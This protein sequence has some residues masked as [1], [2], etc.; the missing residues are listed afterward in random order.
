MTTGRMPAGTHDPT[1]V[2]AADR[3]DDG[4][5]PAGPELIALR[6]APP[7]G[8]TRRFAAAPPRLQEMVTL[9]ESLGYEIRLE[10]LGSE[11]TP[12]TCG[13]CTIASALARVIYTR[14]R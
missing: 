1:S 7:T 3:L 13:D 8:W 5:A 4:G 14:D 10:P 6:R 9:Y 2:P 12:P 11:D